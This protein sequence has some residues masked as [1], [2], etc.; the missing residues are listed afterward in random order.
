MS[1]GTGQSK[2]PYIILCAGQLAV[3]STDKP[4][5]KLNHASQCAANFVTYADT[6]HPGVL[7]TSDYE[8]ISELQHSFMD[9]M[10]TA[11]KDEANRLSA[12]MFVLLENAEQKLVRAAA[13]HVQPEKH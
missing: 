13:S 9:I 8:T 3:L 4:K 6:V 12:D 5:E 2:A 1:N 10:P 11:T 7:A